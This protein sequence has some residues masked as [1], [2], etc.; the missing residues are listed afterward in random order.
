MKKFLCLS[1][2]LAF[3]AVIPTVSSSAII[4]CTYAGGDEIVIDSK[5]FNGIRIDI[6]R[7]SP[8]KMMTHKIHIENKMNFNVAD[9]YL[10]V[11]TS[12]Y[13]HT[14]ALTCKRQ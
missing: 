5:D 8:Q 10:E 6:N 4:V 3:F 9:D 1:I 2:L 12:E 7:T 11:T 13:K 14:Y